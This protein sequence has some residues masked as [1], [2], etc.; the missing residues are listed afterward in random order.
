MRQGGFEAENH[1]VRDK[2]LYENFMQ[3][4]TDQVTIDGKTFTYPGTCG[5]ND[6]AFVSAEKAN[7]P[8]E[9]TCTSN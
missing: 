4:K 6:D 7:G 1:R 2:L 8:A 9:N 5:G 3:G